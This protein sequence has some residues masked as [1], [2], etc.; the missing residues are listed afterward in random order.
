MR[1]RQY[2]AE[3]KREGLALAARSDIPGG[4]LHI[5]QVIVAEVGR[6]MRRFPSAARAAS[7][8]GLAPG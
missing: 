7:W 2:S 3:R 8:A 6:D 5:A 1:K 4:D